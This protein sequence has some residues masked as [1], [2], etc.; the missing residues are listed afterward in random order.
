MTTQEP[1][2]Y[3]ITNQYGISYGVKGKQGFIGELLSWKP[4]SITK[5]A[6]CYLINKENR[7]Y[8]A[9]DKSM[10]DAEVVLLTKTE[11]IIPLVEPLVKKYVCF[12]L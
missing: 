10:S 2:N 7:L 12:V 11:A 9:P 6:D 8:I 1:D 4:I 5:E 3:V